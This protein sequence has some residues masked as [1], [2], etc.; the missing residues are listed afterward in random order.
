MPGFDIIAFDADDTLWHNERMYADAEAAYVELISKYYDRD[1]ISERLFETEMRNMHTLGYGVKAF[2]LS[3]IETAIQLSQG[4]ISADEIGEILNYCKVILGS[5]VELF[6]H[7]AETVPLLAK[8]YPLMLITKGDLL[9]QESKLARSGL[10]ECFRYVEIISDKNTASYKRIF[11]RYNIVPERFL[12]IGNSL[13]S[14]ILPVLE[15][16]AHA[17]HI[18]FE[19]LWLHEVAEA[20]AAA[21]PGYYTLAHMGELPALLKKLENEIPDQ[22]K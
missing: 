13:K 10:A 18:P 3:M 17:V 19:I 15:L 7:V 16:G 6:P 12:M 11:E 5:P 8:K 4:R 20:P 9:D 22:T 14:D 21:H 1:T 2:T